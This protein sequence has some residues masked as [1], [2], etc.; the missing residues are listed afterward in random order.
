MQSRTGGEEKTLKEKKSW[1]VP[2][3]FF[4]RSW[5]PR[6]SKDIFTH[7]HAPVPAQKLNSERNRLR[8]AGP[9]EGFTLPG[10]GRGFWSSW[11]ISTRGNGPQFQIKNHLS[12]LN[13]TEGGVAA[14][15]G[16]Q[17]RAAATERRGEGRGG[18]RRRREPRGCLF[19]APFLLFVCFLLPTISGRW[20]RK[21]DE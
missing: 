14:V 15:L 2:P 1:T 16:T 7:L 10:I 19:R 9:E 5:Q 8:E 11:S 12:G 4:P 18:S 20:M 6:E 21:I 3:F 13:L 17:R